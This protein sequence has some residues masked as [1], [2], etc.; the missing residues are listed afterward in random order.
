MSDWRTR[1][2]GLGRYGMV[3]RQL[4][5]PLWACVLLPRVPFMWQDVFGIPGRL[6]DL[7][8]KAT[9]RAAKNN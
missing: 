3:T 9:A 4:A 1:G 8:T 5:P 7:D 2:L 6:P